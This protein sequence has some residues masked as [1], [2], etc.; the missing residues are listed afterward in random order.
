L[1]EQTLAGGGIAAAAAAAATAAAAVAT[2][3]R[4][5][6]FLQQVPCFI[7]GFDGCLNFRFLGMSL[8]V[9]RILLEP[10]AVGGHAFVE[11]T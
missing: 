5:T 9:V 3:G 11:F 10:R 2:V 6:G 8:R 4:R 1:E 7:E